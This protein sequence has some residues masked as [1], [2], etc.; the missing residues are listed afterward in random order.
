MLCWLA[1]GCTWQLA[2][3]LNPSIRSTT[4]IASRQRVVDGH[5]RLKAGRKLGITEVPVILCDEWTPA[6]V[7]AFRI[8]VNRSATWADWARCEKHWPDGTAILHPRPAYR[9]LLSNPSEEFTG[10]RNV[11]SPFPIR[12]AIV[13]EELA[14][15]KSNFPSWLKS[16]TATK[17]VSVPCARTVRSWNVPL[18]LPR[19][20]ETPSSAVT[21]TPALLWG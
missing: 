8:M 13:P 3:W 11:P 16:P 14:D 5:L 12:I 2:A 4:L 6:Q 21:A 7:K 9:S 20:M 18:P 1:P 19:K 17:S 10:G 15:T